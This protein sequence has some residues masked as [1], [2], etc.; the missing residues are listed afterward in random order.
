[1][2]IRKNFW[3]FGLIL[4][5]CMGA[6]SK[7]RSY[8]EDAAHKS[9]HIGQ[10]MLGVRNDAK[11]APTDT[12]GDYT[13][14]QFNAGGDLYVV[15]EA[16]GTLL[17][18]IDTD[19]GNI[20]TYIGPTTDAVATQGGVGSVTAKL[21]LVTSQLNTIDADT[22][23]IKTNTDPLVTVG[24]GGYVRQDSTATI[25]KEDGGNLADIATDTGTIDE[26]TNNIKNSVASPPTNEAVGG[27]GALLDCDASASKDTT[28]DD[29]YTTT[30][31]KVYKVT[32]IDG[33]VYMG[34]ADV[35]AAGVT[36]AA[37]IWTIPAGTTQY[38]R[39]PDAITTLHYSASAEDVSARISEVLDD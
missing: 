19:T 7:L 38:I 17:G 24:G 15:D 3:I 11:T 36:A 8:L 25:A 33:V 22:G 18:T 27:T 14:P 2:T 12:D 26:D 31:G 35:G 5:V 9:G 32:S 6:S 4:I 21:R 20:A 13:A 34:V 23:T 28:S 10:M 1:M 16:T 29:T 30:A 39:V 37:V